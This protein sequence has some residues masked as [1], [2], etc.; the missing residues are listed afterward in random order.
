MI[1][2]FTYVES[3]N[4]PLNID[5]VNDGEK[6]L[7]TGGGIFNLIKYSSGNMFFNWQYF[8]KSTPIFSL[9]LGHHLFL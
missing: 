5:I 6:I 7:D 3:K 9:R 1:F 4:Y 2:S 8:F